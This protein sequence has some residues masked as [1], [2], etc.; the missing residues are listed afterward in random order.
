MVINR[1]GYDRDNT[2]TKGQVAEA[3]SEGTACEGEL[4]RCRLAAGT[5]SYA[6][7]VGV[8]PN[9][10]NAHGG[11]DAFEKGLAVPD[12]GSGFSGQVPG[13]RDCAWAPCP[14]GFNDHGME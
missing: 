11:A 9:E 14:V 6:R 12:G 7:D 1:T 4:A 8:A 2:S 10:G 13:D 5:T 3:H